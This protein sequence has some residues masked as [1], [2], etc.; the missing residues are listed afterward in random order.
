M[1][2]YRLAIALLLTADGTHGFHV[3][4]NNNNQR[5]MVASSTGDL[6]RYND[7][8]K[9]NQM[10][11]GVSYSVDGV[12]FPSDDRSSSADYNKASQREEA[13]KA[14]E[15]ELDF[16]KQQLRE[17]GVG[18]QYTIEL[19][20]YTQVGSATT[21]SNNNNRRKTAAGMGMTVAQITPGRVISTYELDMD[22]VTIQMAPTQSEAAAEDS[23]SRQQRERLQA[24]A[25]KFLKSLDSNFSGLVV[26]N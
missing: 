21:T 16:R 24:V 4:S 19:P 10:V 22:T 26:T 15:E 3:G 18:S 11:R 20:L 8:I 12:D 7:R 5:K 23:D 17:R 2:N 13:E 14:T 9:S 6:F 1:V 25:P